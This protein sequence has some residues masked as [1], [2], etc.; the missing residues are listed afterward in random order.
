MTFKYYFMTKEGYEMKNHSKSSILNKFNSKR[1]VSFVLTFAL[2]VSLVAGYNSKPSM[3]VTGAEQTGTESEVTHAATE[4]Y[5]DMDY[6]FLKNFSFGNAR[7]EDVNVIFETAIDMISS[8]D[9]R[10][11]SGS[12][13]RTRGYYE[14]N[15]GGGAVYE[16]SQTSKTGSIPLENGLFATLIPDTYTVSGEQWIVVN[17]K[18]LGAAGNGVASDNT[19]INNAALRASEVVGSSDEIERGI[20]W[21]P[22]GEYKC[23]NQLNWGVTNINIVGEGDKSII[24]TDNDYRLYEGYSEFFISVWGAN[25]CYIAD[26]RVEAREVDLYHYMRQ[27][28]FTYSTD[29]YVNRVDLIVPQEAYSAYYFEDKQYSNLCCYTGNKNITVDDCTLVQMSGT[30]RGANIGIL[31]IWSTGEEN[32]VVKNCDIY[33]NARDEQIGVFSTESSSAFVHNVEFLDN[34]V[35]FYQPKYV[36][37]VGNATMRVTVGYSDSHSVDNIRFAGNHFIAECDSKF[38]T[39]GAVTNCVVED[40]I[41]EVLCTYGTWSMVFDSSNGDN[42]NINIR[43]NE[44]YIT[45]NENTGKGNLIGGKLTFEHNRVFTDAVLSFGVLGEVVNYNEFICLKMIGRLTQNTSVVGNS[46]YL[47]DGLNT[48]GSWDREFLGYS[49]CDSTAIYKCQ[50]NKIYNYKRDSSILGV[51]QALIL[52]DNDIDTL[53]FSGNEYYA[54]NTRFIRSNFS[55]SVP[56]YDDRGMYYDNRLFRVRNGHYKNIII[57]DNIL[58]GVDTVPELLEAH[59]DNL[60]VSGNT[61]LTFEED[62]EEELVSHIDI[63]Y[64]GDVV[65]DITT[66]DSTVDLNELVYIASEKD[67]EGNIISEKQVD[68]KDIRWYSTIEGMATVDQNGVVTRQKY[69]DVKIY[70]VPLDGSN[71]YGSCTIHFQKNNAT[72]VIINKDTL[73]LQVGY[74]AY[75]DYTVLPSTASNSLEWTSLDEDVATVTQSGLIEAKALGNTKV[76]CKTK[77]GSNITREINISVTETTVKRIYLSK[78]Y[79]EADYTDI[80]KTYQLSVAAYHPSTAVNKEVGKWVSTD[81]NI[82]KVD[83]NG[84]VTITGNGVANIQAWS[85]DEQCYGSCAFYVAPPA[86]QNLTATSTKNSVSLKWDA[87]DNCYGYYVYMLDNE[88]GEWTTLNNGNYTIYTNFGVSNLKPG[89]EYTF[90]VKAF[91]SR[92]Q[93]INRYLLESEPS[94]VKLST[95]SYIPVSSYS[96]LPNPVENIYVG[97]ARGD[98]WFQYGPAD[99]DYPD[100]KFSCVTE[101]ESIAKVTS[102]TQNP[103]WA[104]RYNYTIEG[105]SPGIT[106]VIISSNDGKGVTYEVPVGIMSRECKLD[107]S[108]LS[109]KAEYRHLT[110]TFTGLEDET[111]IDGYMVRVSHGSSLFHDVE[112]IP[113]EGNNKVYTF[114]QTDNIIDGDSYRYT[115]SP[116]LKD[117]DTY[118]RTYDSN[119]VTVTF[120]EAILITG[121]TTPKELYNIPM[122]TTGS[123]NAVFSPDNADYRELIY[124][125]MDS[126]IAFAERINVQ[127]NTNYGIVTPKRIGVTQLEIAASDVSNIKKYVDIVISPAAPETLLAEPLTGAAQLSWTQTDG[128]EGYFVYRYNETTGVWDKIADVGNNQ[129]T[130]RNLD[131]D[132]IYQYKVAG[133]IAYNGQ[134][135]EGSLS[136]QATVKT[137]FGGFDIKVS[138]Y[139]GV[140]DG[141]YHDAVILNSEIHEGDIVTYS[142]DAINYISVIPKIKNVSDSTNVYVKELKSDGNEYISV[143]TAKISKSPVTPNMPDTDS[144]TIPSHKSL[145][146]DAVLPANWEWQEGDGEMSIESG[147]SVEATAIYVGVDKGNYETETLLMT[148]TREA[149][150]HSDTRLIND[151]QPSCEIDGYTGDY[152]C[153]ECGEIVK[154]GTSIAALGH[155]WNSGTIIKEP[156]ATEEGVKEYICTTCGGTRYEAIE[157]TGTPTESTEEPT[158]STEEPTEST[159]EP[160]ESTEE[161]T[162]STEEPTESTKE[163]T[164]SLEE[165]TESTKKPTESLEEPTESTEKPT[166]SIEKVT[167]GN[168]KNDNQT[169]P[170]TGDKALK[171]ILVLFVYIISSIVIFTHV[172]NKQ[173]YKD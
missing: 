141:A 154:T 94:T 58:Q 117:G 153:I 91:I 139:E 67:E 120:P 123:V 45:T 2:I 88:T 89:T 47:Y 6:S 112:Y 126:K 1:L 44:F 111:N 173:K 59:T 114:E 157:P 30:Y 129:Y 72:D 83:E 143:V 4:K 55:E 108:K 3:K 65:T 109:A 160:T 86:V 78:S 110:L 56:K 142:L 22:E 7:N 26:F 41:I 105:I 16:V 14:V 116:V 161:P 97:G 104:N 79:I 100:L 54:P 31:D 40:N 136:K 60:S 64:K 163:P 18:Q 162:E 80:G 158:E 113:K 98:C 12:I 75:A 20:V 96:S 73:D 107:Y 63:E 23:T 144:L 93:G 69:G 9:I 115:V 17:V 48:Y 82:V 124:T 135:Y 57:Q 11:R 121:I 38:M 145:V 61:Y 156:T 39:F 148:V 159:E 102:I 150:R 171:L 74:R 165:P 27:F 50:D 132:T 28:V 37:V 85:T 166:E 172:I 8:D 168:G 19:A 152:Q 71:N 103:Y 128:A 84:L 35:H 149:C 52:L 81:E 5:K 101:D 25:N 122:D 15:D 127:N 62:L 118:F 33:G 169:T 70:A 125:V 77:D 155:T 151:R 87:V 24:F 10:I 92:W 13:L 99:A 170:T 68:S 46:L 32:I 51:F 90:C 36:N 119:W 53:I 42:K 21:L 147:E 133:Y 29:I 164:E 106:K 131:N 134:K 130:D 137:F 43:N 34:T 49:G 66:T 146:K 167:N 95:Y 76:I 140:Y 138:G